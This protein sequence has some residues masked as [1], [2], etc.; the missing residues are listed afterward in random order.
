MMPEAR[1]IGDALLEESR[2]AESSH[3]NPSSVDQVLPRRIFKKKVLFLGQGAVGKS[4]LIHRLLY[5]TFDR[6]LPP[7]TG[8]DFISKTVCVD[9]RTTVR[10]Q[11]WDTSGQARFRYLVPSCLMDDTSAADAS[12]AVVVYD[13]TQQASFE[14]VPA[15]LQMARSALV[16]DAAVLL[17]ASRADLAEGEERQVRTE[18]GA[19]RAAELGAIFIE[20]SAA[21]GSGITELFNQLA[22][23]P[24]WLLED[25]PDDELATVEPPRQHAAMGPMPLLGEDQRPKPPV[26]SSLGLCRLAAEVIS[27]R[28]IAT[29]ELWC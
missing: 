1:S 21:T 23:V 29:K 4:S 2:A 9:E 15:L 3:R 14:A 5:G 7:T 6:G 27:G 11:L 26:A 24:A 25:S 10:L 12:A 19:A 16:G 28:C 8:I 13:S 22:E 20:T 18:E 17:V